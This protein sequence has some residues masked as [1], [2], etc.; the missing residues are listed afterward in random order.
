VK[1]EDSVALM[2]QRAKAVAAALNV[3][4]SGTATGSATPSSSFG[5]WV[6]QGKVVLD[7]NLINPEK[8]NSPPSCLTPGAWCGG[9]RV[10]TSDVALINNV[11]NGGVTALSVGVHLLQEKE[12]LSGVVVSSNLISA[13]GYSDVAS[14]SAAILLQPVAGK[15]SSSIGRFRNNLIVGGL[16]LNNYAIWEKEVVGASCDP[17]A[18]DH[19]FFYFPI[20]K[21]KL[22]VLYRD[23]N[24]LTASDITSLDMLPGDGQN[25]QGDPRLTADGHLQPDSPCRNAGT[26]QDAP[27]KDFEQQARPRENAFDIGPDEL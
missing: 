1:G 25:L 5:A 18:L 26:A 13:G 14:L 3:L 9:V 24:G 17:A 8:L 4:Q 27:S 22:G 21:P 12:D 2:I 19:N 23:Y 6:R 16:A 20:D 10:S 15:M 7:A 11:I